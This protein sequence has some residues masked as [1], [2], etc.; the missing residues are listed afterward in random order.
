MKSFALFLCAALL[1]CS[2]N[3]FAQDTEGSFKKQIHPPAFRIKASTTA[4]VDNQGTDQ[5]MTTP[6]HLRG[7]LTQ[8]N[9]SLLRVVV[10][11]M[12]VVVLEKIDGGVKARWVKKYYSSL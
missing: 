2:A 11:F 6:R 1:A 7:R 3:V 4:A 10:P 9:E 12:G 5:Q 8:T